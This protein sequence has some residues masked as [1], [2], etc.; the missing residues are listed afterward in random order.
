MKKIFR[1]INTAYVSDIDHLF[2]AKDPPS[3]RVSE[4]RLQEIK[5][6]ERIARLRDTPVTKAEK[7]GGDAHHELW[8]DF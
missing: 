1:G 4:A 2:L 8:E 5:K 6:A 3:A 7:S